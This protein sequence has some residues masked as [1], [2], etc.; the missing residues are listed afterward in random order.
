[1]T[2]ALS[3]YNSKSLK[4]DLQKVVK[5]TFEL[6]PTGRAFVQQEL[7]GTRATSG[8]GLLLSAYHYHLE[9]QKSGF[10]VYQ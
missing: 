2:T 5:S 3:P 8:S 1:M 4:K 6:V 10:G 9:T 7:G